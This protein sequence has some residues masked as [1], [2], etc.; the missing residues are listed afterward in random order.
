MVWLVTQ[1]VTAIIPIADVIITIKLLGVQHALLAM[2][3]NS[4]LYVVVLAFFLFRNT[5]KT[6]RHLMIQIAL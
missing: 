3:W 6:P 5:S 1:D 4:A 2:H